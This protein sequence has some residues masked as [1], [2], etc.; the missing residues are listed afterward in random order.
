GQK[1][2]NQNYI[3]SSLR[4]DVF[5][6]ELG[7]IDYNISDRHKFFYSFR[8]NYR[9]EDRNNHYHNIATGNLLNRINWGS[10][11]DDVY[12]LSP[13][14]V[15]NIRANWTRFT[16]ANDRPSAGFNITSLGFPS[17]IAAASQRSVL[18]IVD[19]NQFSDWGD[20]AGD[21]TPFDI[22][23]I[24]GSL[25]KIT[26]KHSLKFGADVREARESS[27]S[28]GNSGGQYV[29]REDYTRGPLDNSTV[30]PLGQ[31]LA[32]FLLGYPTGGGLDINAFRTN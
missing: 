7:R 11:L 24:F 30:A 25:T 6:G 26:G 20:N 8:H 13:T 29:F 9:V 16:E 2:G 1:D 31:D 15:M 10:T 28:Y 5:D 19:L 22:F 3:D 32:S 21:R 4:H 12:T 27:A 23:Q 18:P 17:Y 14:T